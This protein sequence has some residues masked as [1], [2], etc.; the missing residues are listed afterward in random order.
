MRKLL[1][2]AAIVVTALIL[3]IVA[4]AIIAPMVV[5]PND[6]KDDIADLVRERTG[7]ELT[8]KGDIDVSVFPWLGLELG[9]LALSNAR[10][11]ED[12]P[13]LELDGM[14]IKVKLIPLLSKDIVIKAVRL[15][16]LKAYLGK[17]AKGR[18]NWAD[19]IQA[20][21][22][23]EKTGESKPEAEPATQTDEGGF[24]IE[25]LAV[26]EILVDNAELVWDD[27]QL[28]QYY[29]LNGLELG[30]GQVSLGQPFD[31]HLTSSFESRA[32][33]M[34]G[35]IS[36]TT[37][38]EPAADYTRHMLKGTRL[39]LHVTGADLPGG[40]LDLTMST[41]TLVD[42]DTRV[43]HL[44]NLVLDALELH[45]AGDVRLSG[46]D[47]TPRFEVTLASDEFNPRQVMAALGAAAPET[48]DPKALTKA[49]LDLSVTATPADAEVRKLQLKLDDTTIT[50]SAKAKEFKKPDLAFD[51]TLDAIDVDRY[52]PP[53]SDKDEAK[54][55]PAPAG[56]NEAGKDKTGK[57]EAGGLPKDAIRALVLDGTINAGRIAI[58]GVKL[59]DTTVKVTAK[60]GLVRVEPF[61][62]MLYGGALRTV[63]TADMRTDVTRSA[64]DLKLS[65]MALGSFLNDFMGKEAVTG[66]TALNL[67]LTALGE[68]LAGLRKTVSGEAGFVL[69]NG[70]IRGFQ[71]VPN[72]VREQ[73][74]ATSGKVK[75]TEKVTEQQFRDIKATLK[76]TDGVLRNGDLFLDADNLKASGKGLVDLATETIDYDVRADITG[77]PI[78]PFSIKGSLTDPSTSLDVAEFAKGIAKG[79]IAAPEKAAKEILGVGK[80]A[81]EGIGSGLKGLF[82]GGKKKDE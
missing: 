56:T 11:F 68:D 41:D 29:R 43:I 64:V 77:L 4:A 40:K 20:A 78:I 48:T 72:T 62:T 58:K 24:A 30:T 37:H 46:F 51:V 19:L 36:L 18:T 69:K 7:R 34:Q 55:A 10:G 33:A 9:G 52:L 60:N 12:R 57:D 75:A 16:G 81:L 61:S 17:D 70:A 67:S 32:P 13:M 2:I 6:Y 53:T 1:K 14:D 22:A 44:Q 21:G 74:A 35:D 28:N 66:Q 39:E 26:G 73:A 71:I 80:G 23:A 47:A 3:L 50:G 79:V 38:D 42:L 63:L 54:A 27:R 45:L 25:S 5:Q 31:F 82:G 76:I 65:N 8:F 59:Q 15:D 49:K